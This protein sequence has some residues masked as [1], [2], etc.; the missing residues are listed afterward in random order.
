MPPI[1]T[2][3]IAFTDDSNGEALRNDAHAFTSD[4]QKFRYRKASN[5]WVLAEQYPE[6]CKRVINNEEG[7]PSFCLTGA[8]SIVGRNGK[9]GRVEFTAD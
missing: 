3:R 7:Q 6:G 9:D 2:L 1:A 8:G 4:L 5:D